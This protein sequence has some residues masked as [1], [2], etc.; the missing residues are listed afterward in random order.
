MVGVHHDGLSLSIVP[1]FGYGCR[2]LFLPFDRMTIEPTAW[3]LLNKA[4]GIQM[5]GVDGIEIVMFDNIM[6][7]AAEHSATLAA[8][9]QR[10]DLVRGFQQAKGDGA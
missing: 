10:A 3:D 4:Y 2:E 9:L 5:E 1:P 7:W 6:K 8:M